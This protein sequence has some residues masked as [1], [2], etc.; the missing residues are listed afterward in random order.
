MHISF[1]GFNKWLYIGLFVN[2]YEKPMVV[3]LQSLDHIA[4]L[5]WVSVG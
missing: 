5:P 1:Y 2:V 4:Q 3:V